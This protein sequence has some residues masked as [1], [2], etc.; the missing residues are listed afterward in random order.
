MLGT[1]TQSQKGKAH[2]Q[3]DLFMDLKGGGGD[4]I[5]YWCATTLINT[6]L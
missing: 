6:I 3:Q 5:I 1:N 2:I 4:H